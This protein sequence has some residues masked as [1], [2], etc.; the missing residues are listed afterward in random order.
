MADKFVNLIENSE[1]V[2]YNNQGIRKYYGPGQSFIAL[3]IFKMGMVL[4]F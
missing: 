4:K 1:N 2:R 3:H